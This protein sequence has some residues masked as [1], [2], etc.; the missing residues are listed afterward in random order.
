MFMIKNSISPGGLKAASRQRMDAAQLCAAIKN[1]RKGAAPWVLN[2][3]VRSQ[4]PFLQLRRLAVRPCYGI[5][6]SEPVEF[7]RFLEF[8]SG[9]DGKILKGWMLKEREGVFEHEVTISSFGV[10]LDGK[11]HRTEGLVEGIKLVRDDAPAPLR[12]QAYQIG[13]DAGALLLEKPGEN[14]LGIEA[15]TQPARVSSSS[16][17]RESD[18]FIAGATGIDQL[19]RT[20]EPLLD[21]PSFMSLQVVQPVLSVLV[22]EAYVFHD[23]VKKMFSCECVLEQVLPEIERNLFNSL[24]GPDTS[25]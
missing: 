7:D 11:V 21:N 20:L 24:F 4:V 17:G 23:R 10:S 16:W 5:A 8:L 12:E 2:A 22:R 25:R 9:L 19:H 1:M 18:Q 14:R 3:T 6:A 15:K 13:W